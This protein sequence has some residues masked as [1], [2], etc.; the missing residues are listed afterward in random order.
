MKQ[1]CI[2]THCCMPAQL[3]VDKFCAV[4]DTRLFMSHTV[5]IESKPQQADITVSTDFESPAAIDV[6]IN[7]SSGPP[8]TYTLQPGQSRT[9]SIN[10]GLSVIVRSNSGDV[11]AQGSSCI[12]VYRKIF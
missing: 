8:I 10:D 6:M 1:P 11:K 2:L 12:T 4:F 5:W 3:V 7:L 9:D